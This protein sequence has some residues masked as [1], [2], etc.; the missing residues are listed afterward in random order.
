MCVILFVCCFNVVVCVG[1]F[2]FDVVVFW[3]NYFVVCL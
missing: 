1:V 2:Y 3:R